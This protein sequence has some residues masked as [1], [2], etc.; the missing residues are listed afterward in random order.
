MNLGKNNLT[1]IQTE[2][3]DI[4]VTK[5][6]YEEKRTWCFECWKPSNETKA[7]PLCL[8]MSFNVGKYKYKR[9]KKHYSPYE[10]CSVH[11]FFIINYSSKVAK[12]KNYSSITLTIH[13]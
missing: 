4:F 6:N 10:D 7:N 5:N 1:N 11:W 3:Y 12:K 13:T 2:I 9:K 8:G